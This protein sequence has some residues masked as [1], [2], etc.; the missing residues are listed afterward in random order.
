[1]KSKKINVIIIFI[2]LALLA[3]LILAFMF[4]N[5]KGKQEVDK[6]QEN[7]TEQSLV[8]EDGIGEETGD[9]REGVFKKGNAAKQKT[10]D[11]ATKGGSETI[12]I[13][14]PE[15]TE[16]TDDAKQQQEY[17]MLPGIW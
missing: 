7:N 10:T 6:P 2:I 11:S 5:M 4:H 16:K 1:M 14:K 12:E 9:I 17:N 13:I 15:E 3:L 8:I